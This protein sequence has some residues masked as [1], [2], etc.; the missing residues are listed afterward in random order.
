V[1]G[2]FAITTSWDDGHPLD[3]RLAELLARYGLQ[4]TFYVPLSN[5][6]PTLSAAEIRELS[7]HFEIGAHTVH[8]VRL[9]GL[10]PAAAKAEISESKWRLEEILGK[11]CRVFCFPGGR[12]QGSH[13]PMLKDAGF[14]AARTVELLALGGPRMAGG[15]A[16]I[17]TSVQAYP[18][19][20][21]GYFRN[22]ARR[23]NLGA[24]RGLSLAAAARDWVALALAMLGSAAR[25]GGVF[26]LWGHSWEIAELDLWRPLETVFSA[27]ATMREQAAYVTNSEL[28]PYARRD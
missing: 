24:V 2:L 27:M 26:H 25:T 14:R 9:T 7:R 18:H 15:L 11:P 21:F 22:A 4:G 13:I 17:P 8:H 23:G 1:S 28:T 6:R 16:L 19:S 10:E 20:F 12:F 5:S 3:L